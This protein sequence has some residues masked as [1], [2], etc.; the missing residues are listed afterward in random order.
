V[1]QLLLERRPEPGGHKLAVDH[2]TQ[3]QARALHAAAHSRAGVDQGHVQ[4]EA[5]HQVHARH[6][7][8][9]PPSPVPEPATLIHLHHPDP[10]PA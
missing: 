9:R 6:P 4:V 1:R 5:H 3:L 7:T 8:S 2:D 10:S